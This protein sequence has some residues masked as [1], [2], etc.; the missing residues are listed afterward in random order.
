MSPYTSSTVTSLNIPVETKP[1]SRT[2]ILAVDDDRI[3][4]TILEQALEVFGYT[5]ITA[6]SGAEALT[7]LDDR[8]IAID[9]VIL[10]REMPGMS[11]MD[12]VARMKAT[13]MLATIPII[14]LTGSGGAS[15]IQEG[16][17]AGVYYY[18]VKPANGPLLSSVIGAALRESRQLQE[19]SHELTR[20]D[21]AAKA[22][23][24]CRITVR[25]LDEVQD[26]A[27]L[28][29]TCF[30]NPERVVVGLMELITNAVEH[31]N[32]GLGF[33]EKGRLIESGQWRHEINRRLSM[34][35]FK[36]LSVDVVYQHKEEG[37][38]VQITDQGSGF[39]WRRYWHIDPARATAG[40]GRGIAR[41]RIGAFD[42]LAYNETGNQVTAM[43]E[44][45]T[46]DTSLNW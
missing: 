36:D 39:D 11:G 6:R 7:I 3:S 8:G 26:T 44:A 20:H 37:W 12:V 41:A 16:I 28:L 10:D 45:V 14:M 38:L 4:M 32:L 33:E 31:G 40:H 13:P 25:T 17:D 43:V 46:A 18:L 29:A 5:V 42:R 22:I 24:N 21:A 23:Q 15:Q 30:P 1:A 27:R 34:P 9:A 19:L 35:A 2:T